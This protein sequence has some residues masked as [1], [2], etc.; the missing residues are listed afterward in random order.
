MNNIFY[1][2]VLCGCLYYGLKTG[3]DARATFGMMLT[4]IL[5]LR[6]TRPHP[7]NRNPLPHPTDPPTP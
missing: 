5:W 3:H 4:L 6:T 7:R 2:G 1:L